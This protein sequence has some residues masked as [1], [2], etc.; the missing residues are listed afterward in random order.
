[1][2]DDPIRTA[3]FPAC[4]PARFIIYFPCTIGKDVDKVMEMWDTDKNE[5]IGPY[6]T[7]LMH[8]ALE[9]EILFQCRNTLP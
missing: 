8:I 3:R 7:L 6:V 4:T 2:D 5:T 9:F 1:M